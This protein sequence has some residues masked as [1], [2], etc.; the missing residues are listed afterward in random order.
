LASASSDMTINIM[1]TPMITKIEVTA[2]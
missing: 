1:K 2:L